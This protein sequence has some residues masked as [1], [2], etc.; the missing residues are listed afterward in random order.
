MKTKIIVLFLMILGIDL[1]LTSCGKCPKT[2]TYNYFLKDIAMF[3]T[4]LKNGLEDSA[5]I[6]RSE[7]RVQIVLDAEVK[8]VSINYPSSFLV[9]N[10]IAI[11]IDHR[12]DRREDRIIREKSLSKIELVCNKSVLGIPSGDTLKDF[13][14]IAK[15]NHLR[16]RNGIFEEDS[17]GYNSYNY[18]GFIRFL[19]SKRESVYETP[20]SESAWNVEFIK[21][22]ENN[23][24]VDFTFIVTFSDSTRAEFKTKTVK[25][26][27]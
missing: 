17:L 10:A 7:F 3:N 1:L 26:L 5:V 2:K 24:F 15:F 13:E 18:D 19:N 9:S 14:G 11:G 22:L 23:E 20:A 16:F 21:P 4:D 27:N 12:C 6:D 8:K 25:V